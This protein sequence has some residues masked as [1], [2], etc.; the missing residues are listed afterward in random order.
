VAV[1]LVPMPEGATPDGPIQPGIE[2]VTYRVRSLDQV[3]SWFDAQ[4]IGYAASGPSAVS[5]DDARTAGLRF[6]FH[7]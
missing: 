7:Q 5:P 6:E 4:G 3:T 1:D 2:T